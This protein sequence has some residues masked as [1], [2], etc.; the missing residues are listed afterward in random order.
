MSTILALAESEDEVDSN[1]AR[2]KLCGLTTSPRRSTIARPLQ[3]DK[4][5]RM[6]LRFA[7]AIVNLLMVIS[8][9]AQNPTPPTARASA[10]F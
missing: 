7:V 10:G 4:R 8:L 2:K 5:M 9:G 3:C 6:R 1:L